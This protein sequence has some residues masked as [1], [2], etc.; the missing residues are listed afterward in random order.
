MLSEKYFH[1]DSPFLLLTPRGVLSSTPEKGAYYKC[2]TAV[3]IDLPN[4]SY[5]FVSELWK[6]WINYGNCVVHCGSCWII[7]MYL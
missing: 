7:R 4:F 1:S 5:F 2:S 3:N 6:L